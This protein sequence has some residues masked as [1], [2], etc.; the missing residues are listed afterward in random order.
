MPVP[1]SWKPKAGARSS[2]DF[3]TLD[4]LDPAQIDHDH[5]G[6]VFIPTLEEAGSNAESIRSQL[7]SQ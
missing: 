7:V 2:R 4:R 1:D 6:Q 5:S 3:G